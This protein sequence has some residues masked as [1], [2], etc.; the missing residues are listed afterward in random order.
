MVAARVLS[1]PLC[2]HS[3]RACEIHAISVPAMRDISL[4]A[5]LAARVHRSAE[6]ARGAATVSARR[7]I[8]QRSVKEKVSANGAVSRVPH[9]SALS[10][11]RPS[12][13][14]AYPLMVPTTTEQRG[15]RSSGRARHGAQKRGC[16]V[17][18]ALK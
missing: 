6:Q 12:V 11:A 16:L 7:P 15:P 2:G 18:P 13:Q 8:C 9:V 5:D 10:R 3:R 14:T 4:R 17:G 1:P